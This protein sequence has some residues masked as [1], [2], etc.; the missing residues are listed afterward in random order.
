MQPCT[1]KLSVPSPPSRLDRLVFRYTE[2][3]PFGPLS[4]VSRNLRITVVNI[5]V[6]LH[7]DTSP[8]WQRVRSA[9]CRVT[10]TVIVDGGRDGDGRIVDKHSIVESP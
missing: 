1:C 3:D 4:P 6:L 2:P 7:P 8:S 5:I 10:L 9:S